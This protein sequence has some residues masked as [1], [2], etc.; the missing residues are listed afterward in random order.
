MG[1]RASQFYMAHT[2]TANDGACY[3]N[4]AFLAYYVL[5]SD[6]TVFP[7]V[8]FIILFRSEN[9][10]VEEAVP[11]RSSRTIVDRFRLRYFPVRPFP[12]AVW[13]SH[14]ENDRIK[15]SCVESFH[16]LSG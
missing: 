12:N 13:R 15:I 4:T 8:A 5:V 14:S 9:T 6:T 16:V 3:L 7:A 11:L 2:L 10:F 1:N